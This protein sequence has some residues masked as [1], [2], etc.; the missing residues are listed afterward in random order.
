[1]RMTWIISISF[2]CHPLLDPWLFPPPGGFVRI[3]HRI[4]AQG[5][6][7]FPPIVVLFVLYVFPPIWTDQYLLIW[8]YYNL[9]PVPHISYYSSIIG[10]VVSNI[11]IEHCLIDMIQIFSIALYSLIMWNS[12]FY[13]FYFIYTYNI[14]YYLWIFF[15]HFLFDIFI[16]IFSFKHFLSNIFFQTL[17]IGLL[18]TLR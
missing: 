10:R 9:L 12:S 15:F 3:Q 13:V 5:G 11:I 18:Y 2:P 17:S 8:F 14:E 4:C 16:Q 1:M 6:S 7:V